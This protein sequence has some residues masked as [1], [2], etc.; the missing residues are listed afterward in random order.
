MQTIAAADR[1]VIAG[2]E[3]LSR[4]SVGTG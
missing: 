1:L 4:L 3:V 2:V